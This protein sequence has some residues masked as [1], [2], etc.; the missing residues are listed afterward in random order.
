MRGLHIDHPFIYR[1]IVTTKYFVGG[2]LEREYTAAYG[3][4][5]KPAQAKA[6]ITR[7]KRDADRHNNRFKDSRVEIESHI[8]VSQL[9]WSRMEEGK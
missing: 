7:E 6:A 4:Y 8:E 9:N 2:N 3:G 5:D 1:A